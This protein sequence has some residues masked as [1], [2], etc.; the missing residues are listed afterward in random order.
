M[1]VKEAQIKIKTLVSD[2]INSALMD[3][4]GREI[5]ET[6]QA[7]TR[8]GYGVKEPKG[9]QERLK[10]LT[11]SYKKQ[12]KRLKA[13]GKLSGETTPNT[14]NLTKSGDM[15]NSIDY[16]VNKTTVTVSATGKKNKAKARYQADAGRVAFNLSRSEFNKITKLIENEIQ[17]DIKRKGL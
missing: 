7:R 15:V 17:N 5:K 3:K 12:R 4:V 2:S 14:S 9:K 1:R 13:Q 6:V 16:V 10:G 8:K 11:E